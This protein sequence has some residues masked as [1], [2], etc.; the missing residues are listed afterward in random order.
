MTLAPAA[1]P[2]NPP[3]VSRPRRWWMPALTAV[4][5]LFLVYSLPPYLS[6]DPARSRVQPPQ[7]HPLYYALLAAHVMFGAIAML[8]CL[9]QIWPWFRRRYPP[10][11]A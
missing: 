8:T 7:G 9:P 3:P 5:V 11:T 6:L 1:L 4:V 10:H 2:A